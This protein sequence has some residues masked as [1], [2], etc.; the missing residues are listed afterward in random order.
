MGRGEGGG[1]SSK[2]LV[3]YTTESTFRYYLPIPSNFPSL[4]ILS[5]IFLNLLHM[6]SIMVLLMAFFQRVLGTDQS[7]CFLWMASLREPKAT[8]T[9]RG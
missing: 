4:I 8:E 9:M 1:L 3:I 2:C 5:T 7:S 6:F